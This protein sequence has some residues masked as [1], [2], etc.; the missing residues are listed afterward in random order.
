[1]TGIA[2]SRT[3][4]GK[5][6]KDN[7]KSEADLHSLIRRAGNPDA[8]STPSFSGTSGSSNVGPSGT[9]FLPTA[10]GTM[11]GPIA[12]YP[13][14][15]TISSGAI[16]IGETTD[17]FSSRV[18]VAPQTIGGPDDLVTITGAKH[19]GQL[20]IIQGTQS[21][22]LTLKTTG[23]IET[24]DGNDFDIE[25]DDN[26][27]FI[28]DGTDNKWQQ[29]TI[30]KQGGG[31][32]SLSDNN[33]WTGIQTF[34]G[35]TFNVNTTAIN[36]GDATSDSI[37]FLGKA[38]TNLDMNTYDLKSVDRLLFDTT[39]TD[40]LATTDRGIAVDSGT[41]NHLHYN[42]PASTRHHFDI[43]GVTEF[44]ISSTGVTVTTKI[45][46]GS[47]TSTGNSIFNGNT[48]LGNSSSDQIEINGDLEVNGE[49]EFNDEVRFDDDVILGN[50]AADQIEIN[51][52]LD[53]KTNY[54]TYF[55]ATHPACTGFITVKINGSNR[56]IW[57]S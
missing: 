31:G 39:G 30:G 1:M 52:D 5:R 11:M 3:R 47:I 50:T 14:L 37:N 22:T 34:T 8:I 26:I 43:A 13:V 48:T 20:L 38:G 6:I 9:N 12:F 15:V 10:G 2:K 53:F 42:V 19:A 33:T 41:G 54:T 36:L 24:I 27:I 35:T 16:D 55:S 25:D 46:T 49:V 23:N 51:G 45:T 40:D 44:N 29:V 28:F 57:Y 56:N 18:I 4:I 32:V 21:V 7:T 17:D